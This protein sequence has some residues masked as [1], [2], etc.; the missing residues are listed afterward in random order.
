MHISNDR[1]ES[2]IQESLM[3]MERPT[4]YKLSFGGSRQETLHTTFQALIQM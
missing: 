4:V 3:N 1:S 2:L